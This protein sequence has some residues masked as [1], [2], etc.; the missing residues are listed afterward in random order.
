MSRK[1]TDESVLIERQKWFHRRRMAYI[2]LFSAIGL[3]FMLMVFVY[4]GGK[5][6]S[7]RFSFLMPL[8]GSVE[9]L[10]LGIVMAYAGLATYSDVKLGSV[11]GQASNVSVS[12]VVKPVM[13]SS[14]GDKATPRVFG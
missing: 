8:L 7:D 2:S 4:L 14:A 11:V 9:T 13:G 5:D 1:E 6:I 3:V 10:L 12:P